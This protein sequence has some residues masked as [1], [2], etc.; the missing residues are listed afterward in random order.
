MAPDGSGGELVTDSAIQRLKQEIR[1]NLEA[2]S[3]SAYLQNIKAFVPGRSAAIG[4][5]VPRLRDIVKKF[6]SDHKELTLELSCQLLTDFCNGRCREEILVGVFLVASFRRRFSP[7]NIREL[8]KDVDEWVDRLDNW[9]TC[10]QLA[11]NVAGEVVAID[12][13]LINELVMWAR[14]DNKW[15]RRFAVATVTVLNQKGRR[16]IKETLAVCD[17]VMT[18]AEPVVQ[19][20]VG[21][22]L[23]EA[24]SG[25]ENAVFAFLKRWKENANPRIFREGSQKLPSN[26]KSALS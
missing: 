1:K 21:W 24:T 11:M 4:V 19:K 10:D 20:A 8:W 6:K 3:D 23:R 22:A 2:N 17:P 9:E 14:S 18:D 26:L 13:R 5:R 15:R 16:H 7:E 12:L 25:G